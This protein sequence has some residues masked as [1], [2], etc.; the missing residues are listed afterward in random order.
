MS[1]GTFIKTE[2]YLSTAKTLYLDNV[3]AADKIVLISW[4]ETSKVFQSYLV[5]FIE[6]GNPNVD[7]LSRCFGLQ[8]SIPKVM[9]IDSDSKSIP[10]KNGKRSMQFDGI[11]NP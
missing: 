8:S 5:K 6:S 9:I 4:F 11:L 10:E 3:L 2:N 7:G 1:N